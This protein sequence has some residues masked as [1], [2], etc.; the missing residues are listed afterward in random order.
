VA[1]GTAAWSATGQSPFAGTVVG[2]AI[3]LTVLVLPFRIRDYR[4]PQPPPVHIGHSGLSVY[5]AENG[6]WRA[7]TYHH[8]PWP[9][10]S[11]LNS[12]PPPTPEGLDAYP[13]RRV[14]DRDVGFGVGAPVSGRAA[15]SWAGS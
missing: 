10:V 7:G 14:V 12:L 15:W 8:L 3:G 13:F 11:E 4:R 5:L 9:I 2:I 1:A 6:R